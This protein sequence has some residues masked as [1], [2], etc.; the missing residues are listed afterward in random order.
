M[1][2]S[3]RSAVLLLLAVFAVLAITMVPAL[4]GDDPLA[5][6]SPEE[7]TQVAMIAG[8]V[9]LSILAVA[10]VGCAIAVLAA[11]FPSL[12]A[13]MDRHARAAGT[14]SPLW[15]GSVVAF[16][17]VI[18]LAGA[19]KAGDVAAFVAVVL[20]GLPALLLWAAGMMAVL[21]L[22]GERLLGTGGTAAG[23][24]KRSVVGSIA[25]ALAVLPGTLARIHVVNLVLALVLFGWPLGVGLGAVFARLRRAPPAA[26]PPPA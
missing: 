17:A 12:A 25:L 10:G 15:I 4:A 2:F 13:A 11:A 24:L 16:G 23:P 18:A 22:L 7:L 14:W 1:R 19:G 3:L 5:K 6:G 21:P 20:L 8:V 9:V 26:G